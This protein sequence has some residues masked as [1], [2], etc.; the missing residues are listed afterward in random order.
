MGESELRFAFGKNWQNFVDTCMQEQR[1]TSAVNSIKHL[2]NAQNLQTKTFL[3]IGCGSGLFSLAAYLLGAEKVMSFDYD[4][5]SVQASIRLRERMDISAKK[6]EIFRGSILDKNFYV[7]LERADI[8]Y[9]WGVLYHTGAMWQALDNAIACLKSGGMLAIS[10]YNNLEK[11]LGGM[12]FWWR[13]KRTYNQLSKIVQQLMEYIYVVYFCLGVAITLRNP[14]K[15]I[16]G[17]GSD[18]STRGMDFWHN[19]RDWVGGFPY[20]YA[21]AGEIFTYVHEKHELEL[22][23]LETHDGHVYNQFT[24]HKPASSD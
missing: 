4:P 15:I 21:T 20:E 22:M 1:I 14:F 23:F 24:F 16:D 11:R 2:L 8:V 9:S 5:D 17:Y 18:A 19:L 13:V 7:T 6:W 12:T 3:D 10:I